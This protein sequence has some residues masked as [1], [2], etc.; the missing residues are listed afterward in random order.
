MADAFVYQF[1]LKDVSYVVFKKKI[2]PDCGAKMRKN[3]QRSRRDQGLSQH[4]I[5]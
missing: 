1:T 4:L 5:A 2:C 3:A